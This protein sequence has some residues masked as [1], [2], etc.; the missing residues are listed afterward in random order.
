MRSNYAIA[1]M[2]LHGDV[3]K[4]NTHVGPAK[5]MLK[6]LLQRM[7]LGGV[8]VGAD[9]QRMNDGSVIEARVNGPVNSVRITTPGGNDY[10]T[11]KYK[12]ALRIPDF[13]SG[14]FIH[15]SGLES[16]L[17]PDNF[18]PTPLTLLPR[19]SLN[20]E[21]FNL[22]QYDS[23][24]ATQF[25]GKMRKVVQA[26][27]GFGKKTHVVKTPIGK[28]KMS[29]SVYNRFKVKH[30]EPNDPRISVLRTKFRSYVEYP[31]YEHYAVTQGRTVQYK[32]QWKDTDGIYTDENGRPWH[33]NISK[34]N[35]VLAMPLPLN[36]NTTTPEFREFLMAVPY[37]DSAGNPATY[38]DDAAIAM[39]DAFGGFPTGM[40]MP[41]DAQLQ[42]YI[43]A[44]EILQLATPSDLAPFYDYKAI[45]DR[46]GWAFSDDGSK[47]DNTATT[48][49]NSQRKMAHYRV[50]INITPL[51]ERQ[52]TR[53]MLSL[54]DMIL[55]VKTLGKWERRLLL[56]KTY[57]AT[58]EQLA[59]WGE[60]N[61]TAALIAAIKATNVAPVGSGSAALNAIEAGTAT[62]EPFKKTPKLFGG[63]TNGLDF[64][65]HDPA[66]TI[67]PYD[68][69]VVVWYDG[70]S[71]RQL[72]CFYLGIEDEQ[73]NIGT[74]STNAPGALTNKYERKVYDVR[75]YISPT[76][77]KP[78]PVRT[79]RVEVSAVS[80]Y[81]PTPPGLT[82]RNGAY[83]YMQS[84]DAPYLPALDNIGEATNYVIKRYIFHKVNF[85]LT[86]RN[87]ARPY[88]MAAIP[89]GE[90]SGCAIYTCD[91]FPR[92][93]INK[94]TFWISD[95]ERT[96]YQG[97]GPVAVP[98]VEYDSMP[99]P[100]VVD[101]KIYNLSF[102][103]AFQSTTKIGSWLET[104][105]GEFGDAD[106]LS[107]QAQLNVRH[108][109]PGYRPP[110]CFSSYTDEYIIYP[111]PVKIKETY[112]YKCNYFLSGHGKIA[113]ASGDDAAGSGDYVQY[114]FSGSSARNMFGP[115]NALTYSFNFQS[116][117]TTHG[118]PAY[119]DMVPWAT[120]FVGH[121]TDNDPT[122]S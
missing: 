49:G 28:K 80:V 84:A 16:E 64:E 6:S 74:I 100:D 19:D 22:A 26:L 25:T 58:D 46:I 102:A 63:N 78:D 1:R 17:T 101:F 75:L 35:G 21:R 109:P 77:K 88:D 3:D 65:V 66:E 50:S 107:W 44:G 106:I 13:Y 52:P 10:E 104:H 94:K 108:T 71:L 67:A 9:T 27:M 57:R 96:V 83:D 14:V 98:W 8:E 85:A 86:R 97:P 120:I 31:K 90:R 105:K 40:P 72:R 48:E 56:C 23:I 47:A 113:I 70:N 39:L 34:A 54:R 59:L 61:D 62:T 76:G 29:P 95:R 41:P 93:T 112:R 20:W 51:N 91:D 37:D 89:Y 5:Q 33:V 18:H 81:D 45:M 119:S 103:I 53:S 73:F 82:T 55:R 11:R 116:A 32:S 110:W 43:D 111:P 115:S 122:T 121:M 38:Q 36:H 87:V 4:A 114:Y 99:S 42:S 69:P 12:F 117:F 118:E 15:D 60:E 24:I 2:R 68:I 30:F 7:A 79:E 92:K